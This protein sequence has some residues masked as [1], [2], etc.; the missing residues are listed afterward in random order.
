MKPKMTAE[1][2]AQLRF[3]YAHRRD[4]ETGA[5]PSYVVEILDDFAALEVRADLAERRL[6]IAVK[7]LEKAA[8]AS[9]PSPASYA[10]RV[11][12]DALAEIK[13][14]QEIDAP[15]SMADIPDVR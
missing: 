14:L 15:F 1:H 12:A 8:N 9:L 4:D 7:A 11:A 10:E 6:A 13:A 3:L 5:R 2:R